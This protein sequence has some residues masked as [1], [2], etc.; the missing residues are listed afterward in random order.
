MNTELQTIRV[1]RLSRDNFAKFGDVIEV[2]D[3]SQHFTINDGFTERYHDLAKVDVEQNEGRTL[4]SLFRAKPLDLPIIIKKMERHPL[5]SQAFMPLSG[6]AYLVVVAPA[7]DFDESNIEVFYAKSNQGVN[8]H[9]GIWHHFCLILKS[10]GDFLVVDR[11][12][13]GKNCDEVELKIPMKIQ[14]DSLLD[15]QLDNQ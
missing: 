15:N 9:V 10:E 1:N 7:G 14:L 11:G 13:K 4:I 5:A 6:N 2:N 8:Y 3:D 12:G